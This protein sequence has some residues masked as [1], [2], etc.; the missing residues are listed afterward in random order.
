[1]VQR[2][3]AFVLVVKRREVLARRALEVVRVE[4]LPHFEHGVD[5]DKLLD[6]FQGGLLLLAAASL[7]KPDGLAVRGEEEGPPGGLANTGVLEDLDA[8]LRGACGEQ[9]AGKG[10]LQ[11]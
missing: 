9:E 4:P 7:R 3:V 10:W 11:P 5:W 1:M 2:Y 8:G 6:A